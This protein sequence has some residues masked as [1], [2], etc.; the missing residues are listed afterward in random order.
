MHEC[1]EH[2]GER[3]T[4]CSKCVDAILT[5]QAQTILKE[6]ELYIPSRFYT[7]DDG[8]DYEHINSQN[9]SRLIGAFN[10]VKEKYKEVEEDVLPL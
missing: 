7:E 3:A 1:S 10:Q 8:C 6:V 5:N 2:K 4:Y 9:L